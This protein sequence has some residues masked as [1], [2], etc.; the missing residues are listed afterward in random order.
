MGP[1]GWRLFQGFS[2]GIEGILST[3]FHE[4]VR[5]APFLG[6]LGP[7]AKERGAAGRGTGSTAIGERVEHSILGGQVREPAYVQ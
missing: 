4:A 1:S 6:A 2:F 3:P 5:A 7:G